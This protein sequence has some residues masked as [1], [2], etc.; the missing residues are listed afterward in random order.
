MTHLGVIPAFC[1]YCGGSSFSPC[2]ADSAYT[3]ADCGRVTYLNSKPSACAVIVRDGMVLLVSDAA[4][5]PPSWDLP[6]G[7]LLYGEPP[8]E[9]LRREIK[10]ELNADISVGE[11]LAAKVDIYG[12]ESCY[13]LNLFY[14]AELLSEDIRA[15]AEIK[16]HGWFEVMRLPELKYRS[17][18][19]ILTNQTLLER[20]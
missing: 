16:A 20:K 19:E 18:S 9:G 13:T 6:G 3:C 14:R 5:D 15:G 11:I 1:Q 2:A 7:F 12:S 8:E 4:T 10:E 17:T